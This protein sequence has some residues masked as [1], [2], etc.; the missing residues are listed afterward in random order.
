MVLEGIL[1]RASLPSA[2]RG[3]PHVSPSWCFPLAPQ[4]WSS[5]CSEGL[6]LGGTAPSSSALAAGC[7]V[8]GW[9]PGPFL[10]M[11]PGPGAGLHPKAR[12]TERYLA[13]V[14]FFFGGWGGYWILL[15]SK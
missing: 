9:G 6:T 7:S 11:G 10:G 1:N 2:T 5:G 3:R 15:P 4:P 12:Q 14:L 13:L 8:Q